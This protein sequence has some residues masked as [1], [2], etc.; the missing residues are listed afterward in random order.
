[1]QKYQTSDVQANQAA[2]KTITFEED[3][4]SFIERRAKMMA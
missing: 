1:M 2:A 4:L 3:H